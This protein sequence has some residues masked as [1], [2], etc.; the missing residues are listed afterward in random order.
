MATSLQRSL[1]AVVEWLDCIT[2]Y[3]ITLPISYSF[4]LRKDLFVNTAR[5]EMTSYFP[6]NST[7]LFSVQVGYLFCYILFHVFCH[8]FYREYCLLLTANLYNMNDDVYDQKDCLNKQNET[9]NDQLKP[10]KILKLVE[11]VDQPNQ[12]KTGFR[13]RTRKNPINR[14]NLNRLVPIE[15][16]HCL[17]KGQVQGFF[18]RLVASRRSKA[19]REQLVEDVQA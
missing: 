4:A 3:N 13:N 7:E 5:M 14:T 18:L 1:S 16:N 11:K 6:F 12:P 8:I 9:N 2:L 19:H 17:T 15:H 10:K